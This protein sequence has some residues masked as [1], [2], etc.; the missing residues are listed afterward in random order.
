MRDER[1]GRERP[2]P[3]KLPIKPVDEPR[4]A[5]SNVGG[6]IRTHGDPRYAALFGEAMSRTATEPPDILTHGFHS[7]PARMHHAIP[8]TIFSELGVSGARVLDP[9]AGGG[10]VLVEAMRFGARGIGIDLNPLSQLVV[11]AK[12]ALRDARDQQTFLTAVERVVMGS[13]ERVQTRTPIVAQL[14][15]EMVALYAPHVLK[16]LAG[17]LEEIRAVESERDA[18]MLAA[19]FSSLVVKLSNKKADTS[20]EITEKRLRK[21][22][23]SELFARKSDELAQRWDALFH[24]CPPD[25]E[26]PRLFVGDA[27][28]IPELLGPRVRADLVVTSPPYGG[29]YDYYAHHALRLAWLDL[30]DAELEANEMGSRRTLKGERAKD[31]FDAEMRAFLRSVRR[32]IADD[33][34][35]IFV[36][37]DADFGGA[38]VPA[39]DQLDYLAPMEGLRLLAGA[40]EAKHDF[41][42]G[43][44][45]E[46]H[47]I[48]M[49]PVRPDSE[50]QRV[51]GQSRPQT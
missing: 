11:S 46:E 48:A 33:G 8:G 19:V 34:L 32:V 5:L 3:A 4:R 1:R 14:P 38:R 37:G 50:R 35:V 6:A 51:S 9:C 43:P 25:A 13:L 26:E 24:A 29:T 23:A 18:R 45:R 20:E 10:T 36:I 49:T 7:W 42:G 40:S 47:V 31:R 28:R 15:R 30:P 27:R 41:R 16:E 17:L 21:G 22:L 12:C 44:P 2:K 39:L